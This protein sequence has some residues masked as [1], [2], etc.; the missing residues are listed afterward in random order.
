MINLKLSVAALLLTTVAIQAQKPTAIKPEKHISLQIPEPS[1]VCISADGTKMYVVS[2]SGYL[3]ETDLEGSILRKADYLGIDD[4][5]VYADDKFVYAVE[6]TTRKV[7]IFDAATLKL[8]RTVNLSYS[9]GR[10]KG[11]EALTFN[12]AKNKFV[13]LTEKDP[14]YL[15][16]LDTD[17]KVE[18]EINLS[19]IARDI[20]AATYY[21]NALWLLSDEDRTL[22]RL[23]P[24]TYEV[25]AKWTLPL[26]NPEGLAFDKAGNLLVISDDM[27]TLYFFKNPEK[28]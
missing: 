4:E 11:Y 6:E 26:I 25:T 14:V 17:L 21:N 5:A 13:I 23:N 2:D 10:N 1:D 27:K 18:N 15:F 3:F 8:I 20:S 16:E 22:F 19:K 12:K 28:Q 9:G 7:K 24:K